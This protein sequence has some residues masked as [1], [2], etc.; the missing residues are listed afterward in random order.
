MRIGGADDS[1][2]QPSG[3]SCHVMRFDRERLNGD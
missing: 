3:I 1:L 2:E